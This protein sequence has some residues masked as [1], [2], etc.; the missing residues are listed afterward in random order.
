[1]QYRN[2]SGYKIVT[3]IAVIVGFNWKTLYIFINQI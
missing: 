3:V 1:M 2:D